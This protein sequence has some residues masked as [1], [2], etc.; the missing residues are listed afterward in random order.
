MKCLFLIG[1]TRGHALMAFLP[2]NKNPKTPVNSVMMGLR[3]IV[4]FLALYPRVEKCGAMVTWS[5]SKN[6]PTKKID[7]SSDLSPMNESK[8]LLIEFLF[9]S[10]SKERVKKM[11]PDCSSEEGNWFFK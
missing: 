3:Q 8:V 4:A 7:V 6:N 1:N 2:Y 5:Q 9:R 10:P 11:V